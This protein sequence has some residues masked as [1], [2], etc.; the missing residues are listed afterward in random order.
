[1]V[2]TNVLTTVAVVAAA[3]ATV[4]YMFW[5]KAQE[6]KEARELAQ[7][8]SQNNSQ[9]MYYYQ[10]P[11]YAPVQ[12][13][14]YYGNYYQTPVNGFYEPQQLVYT[15]DPYANTWRQTYC[16]QSQV[17]NQ[18]GYT[19]EF[20]KVIDNNGANVVPNENKNS[21]RYMTQQG[22]NNMRVQANG[23]QLNMLT[24]IYTPTFTTVPGPQAPAPE[25]VY[26]DYLGHRDMVDMH[27]WDVPAFRDEENGREYTKA[28]DVNHSYCEP[29]DYMEK[30]Y[31]DKQPMQKVVQF[32]ADS[33]EGGNWY[34][35]PYGIPYFRHWEA[36]DYLK[37]DE[38]NKTQ[39][40]L[41]I[42]YTPTQEYAMRGEPMPRILSPN[43]EKIDKSSIP[44][45]SPEEKLDYMAN[46]NN[47]NQPHREYD[48]HNPNPTPID[49]DA[50]EY[51][52]SQ[53]EKN[54]KN[55]KQRMG[56]MCNTSVMSAD[57]NDSQN[58]TEPLRPT[59]VFK[60]EFYRTVEPGEEPYHHE[61]EYYITE[62]VARAR[63]AAKMNANSFYKTVV[64]DMTDDEFNEWYANKDKVPETPPPVVDYSGHGEICGPENG[65][66]DLSQFPLLTDEPDPRRKIIIYDPSKDPK[67]L[68]KREGI[69]LSLQETAQYWVNNGEAENCG[70]SYGDPTRPVTP[71]G[72]HYAPPKC[73]YDDASYY[74]AL[75][76]DGG[77]VHYS[78]QDMLYEIRYRNTYT[79]PDD[80]PLTHLC[81]Y[82]FETRTDLYN[83]RQAVFKKYK[84]D[85]Y[86]LAMSDDIWRDDIQHYE[87]FT[88]FFN[89]NPNFE[90]AKVAHYRWYRQDLEKRAWKRERENRE[91]KA[92]RDFYLDRVNGVH[93][94]KFC[95]KDPTEYISPYYYEGLSGELRQ[96]PVATDP[97]YYKKPWYTE[98]DEYY[99]R[100]GLMAEP[101]RYFNSNMIEFGYGEPVAEEPQETRGVPKMFMEA[102]NVGPVDYFDQTT[103][104]QQYHPAEATV[105]KDLKTMW[106]QYDPADPRLTPPTYND[107]SDADYFTYICQ[108]GA[109]DP[110]LSNYDIDF[111]QPQWFDANEFWKNV[112]GDALMKYEEKVMRKR[113]P[114]RVDARINEN[115]LI[116][117]EQTLENTAGR[118]DDPFVEVFNLPSWYPHARYINNLLNR[119]Q[120]PR[121][122]RFTGDPEIDRQRIWY[123]MQKDTMTDL[124][125]V[126]YLQDKMEALRNDPNYDP[127]KP[128][129]VDGLT[130][131][132]KVL[133]LMHNIGP[134]VPRAALHTWVCAD[135]T[136]DA[137]YDAWEAKYYAPQ[138]NKSG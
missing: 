34:N 52:E 83:W 130:D 97:D 29:S 68:V 122:F 36:D 117:D 119:F 17:P 57:D 90:L 18:S 77:G 12:Q 94:I 7:L 127:R 105:N 54:I 13:Q 1:M 112:P 28:Y 63:A 16:N 111:Q 135:D 32:N 96:H 23:H 45:V 9:P 65:G 76:V 137:I 19:G 107:M 81:P 2:M 106:V 88:P 123:L 133:I 134:D 70:Y 92:R 93:N 84:Y 128:C 15:W 104:R 51:H 3:A 103:Y 30:E 78:Y 72:T 14:G 118:P 8:C 73:P 87:Y 82:D 6:A 71:I 59:R 131:E 115:M 43:A 53:Y 22:L 80:D 55:W 11:E 48:I 102:P 50:H 74:N 86:P 136:L 21:R 24:T 49:N 114:I 37:N 27:E 69:P 25:Y 75:F 89:N 4:V 99:R 31:Y 41:G 64:L 85:P 38:F 101:G 132:E 62:E 44:Y 91:K 35:Q 5:A 66:P 20:Y 108:Q 109:F 100:M 33:I 46:G 60:G 113:Y 47:H 126:E 110:S 79:N 40:Q 39:Q 125:K 98:G 42:Y 58:V 120:A 121:G 67:P 26:E 138:C 10:Q 129:K 116:T 61:F 124:E 56:K 95:P